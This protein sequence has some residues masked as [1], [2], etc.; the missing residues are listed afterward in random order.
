MQYHIIMQ[1][2]IVPFLNLFHCLQDLFKLTFDNVFYEVFQG[3]SLSV[4]E[5]H[6]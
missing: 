3:T 4:S 2:S 6:S 1:I 5:S